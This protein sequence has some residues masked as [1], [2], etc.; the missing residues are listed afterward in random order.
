MTADSEVKGNGGEEESRVSP[1]QIKITAR[2]LGDLVLVLNS[3][4]IFSTIVLASWP[5]A[6]LE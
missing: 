5:F 3:A 4:S 6:L 1:S 2:E